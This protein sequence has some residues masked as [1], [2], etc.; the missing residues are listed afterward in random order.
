M[1]KTNKNEKN[2]ITKRVQ[3]Q[4]SSTLFVNLVQYIKRIFILFAFPAMLIPREPNV[5]ASKPKLKEL[6]ARSLLTT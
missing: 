1:E 4:T 3:C 2:S 6:L 5:Q